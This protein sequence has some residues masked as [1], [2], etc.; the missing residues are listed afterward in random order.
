MIPLL[1]YMFFRGWKVRTAITS[2]F[3]FANSQL[4]YAFWK[5]L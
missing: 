2:W 1:A 4:I 5:V 3:L